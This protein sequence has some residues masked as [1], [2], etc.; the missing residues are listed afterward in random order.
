VLVE[1]SE[2]TLETIAA[3]IDL[4]PVRAGIVEDPADYA[5]SSYGAAVAGEKASQAGL[6]RVVENAPP[7]WEEFMTHYR[8]L[9]FGDAVEKRSEQDGRVVRRG[10]TGEEI[11]KVRAKGGRLSLPQLLRCRIRH[12]TAGGAFGSRDFIESVFAANRVYFSQ[13]RKNGARNAGG[14]PGLFSLRALSG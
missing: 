11:A 5:W 6:M 7:T 13:G 3:Y 8:M 9:I 14:L 4:N 12:F 10:L 1:E 2:Q